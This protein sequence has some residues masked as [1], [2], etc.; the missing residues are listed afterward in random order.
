M[1][2]GGRGD[3]PAVAQDAVLA[4]AA[5]DRRAAGPRRRR[6]GRGR[7]ARRAGRSVP[8]RPP[9]A[10]R[11]SRRRGSRT[12]RRRRRADGFAPQPP[13][14]GS[15]STTKSPVSACGPATIVPQTDAMWPAPQPVR[16]GAAPSPARSAPRRRSAT[17]SRSSRAR[18]ARRRGSIPAGRSPAAA[19]RSRGSPPRSAFVSA[20]NATC[21]AESRPVEVLFTGP[22]TCGCEP[23]EVADELVVGD[24]DLHPHLERAVCRGR[25]RRCSRPRRTSPFGSFASSSRAIVSPCSISASIVSS[26]DVDAVLVA[27]LAERALADAHRRRL[28]HQVADRLLGRA[29]VRRDQVDERL[30]PLAAAPD[31]D[32][33]ELEPLLVD[34]GGVGREG[35]GR[36]AADLG[37]VRLR[38][39]E[40]ERAGRRRRSARRATRPRGASRRRCTGRS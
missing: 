17:P 31:L 6:S 3:D 11:T 8:R 1:A 25:R 34:L 9:P 20:L 35:A 40:R 5:R 15:T 36:H 10:S 12:G 19:R 4:D 28:R 30:V 7:S 18:A 22:A 23:R 2:A 38:H 16:A 29:H 21:A 32:V 26:T 14:S 24:R 39:R 13:T 27:D 33:R 37:P